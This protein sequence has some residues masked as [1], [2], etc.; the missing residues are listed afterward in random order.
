MLD[1]GKIRAL[2]TKIITPIANRLLKL[3]ITAD[4]V[5]IFGAII[6]SVISVQLLSQ[7]KFLSGGVLLSLVSFSDLLD[8]TMAR[9][10]GITSSWGSFLDSTLDRIVDGA[11][12]GS[13]IFYYAHEF[14][15]NRFVLISLIIGLVAAQ[16][17][18]YTRARWESLGV[19]G[20]VGLAERSE[21]MIAIISGLIITGLG[22][23][24]LTYIIHL[25]ALA[26]VYTVLQRI[27]FVRKQLKI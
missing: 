9:L 11:I 4:E 16:V 18:S 8:G 6:A 7:G 22:L 15:S 25:L 23:N 14:E 3:G 10:A 13:L 26:S 19:K 1:N 21:R 5:T 2:S 24:V 17:T 27:L 12:Y 20:K